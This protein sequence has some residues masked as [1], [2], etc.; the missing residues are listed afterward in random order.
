MSNYSANRTGRNSA[1]TAWIVTAVIA[2]VAVVALVVVIVVAVSNTPAPGP[3]DSNPTVQPTN[4]PSG[5]STATPTVTPTPSPSTSNSP[6]PTASPTTTPS[7]SSSPSGSSTPSPTPTVDPTIAWANSLYGTFAPLTATGQGN[8]HVAV[9]KGIKGAL[10]TVTNN[11]ADDQVFRVEVVN[12]FG[13]PMSRLVDVQGDYQGT[14]AYGLASLIGATPTTILIT[15]AGNWSVEFAPVSTASM[16][17]GQGTSND[18]LLYGGGA[19]PMTVQSLTSGDFTM[20]SFAGSDPRPTEL[21]SQTGWWTGQVDLPE[22]PLVLVINSD[23]AWNLQ[24]GFIT[25]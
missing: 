21:T 9:P 19:G 12:Q 5:S 6:T 22:G 15:S 25:Q 8:S 18:V 2:A 23:G 20:T 13:K 24:I 17:L 14:V 16:D 4:S 11:G 1:R 7:G 3:T 10:L